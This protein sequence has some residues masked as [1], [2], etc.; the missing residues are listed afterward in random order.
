M[1]PED[2]VLVGVINRKRDFV[3]ARDEQWY[4]IPQNQLP[5]GVH[6]DYLAFFLSGGVFKEQSGGIHYYARFAGVELVYR[7]DLLPKEAEHPRAND[8]YYRVAL[9]DWTSKQPPILNPTRR[10]VTFIHTT[11]DRF[12]HATTIADLYSK[13]DYFVDRIYHALRSVGIASERFWEVETKTTGV[14]PGVRVL[15]EDGTI[16]ASTVRTP[17]GLYM[18]EERG[19]DAIFKAIIEEIQRRG[20]PATIS[21]PTEG[22]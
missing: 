17:D 8:V 9:K 5:N 14:P 2:R 10:T 4:R 12:V 3:S 22:S 16:T 6:T 20:G 15:C 21:I 19:E 13:A 11:W 7:R 1:F 18:D